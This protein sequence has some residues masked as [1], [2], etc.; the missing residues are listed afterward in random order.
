MILGV[1]FNLF[2]KSSVLQIDQESYSFRNEE[3]AQLRSTAF[4]KRT[5]VLVDVNRNATIKLMTFVVA[6]LYL[7]TC[8]SL[9]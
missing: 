8:I 1:S 4:H 9:F 3:T 5:Y 7:S 6:L 2:V